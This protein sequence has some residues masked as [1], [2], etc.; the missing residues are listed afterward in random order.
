MALSCFS[1]SNSDCE[2]NSS[3]E[4]RREAWLVGGYINFLDAECLVC[5]GGWF[6]T[7]FANSSLD[8]EGLRDN[9][10]WCRVFYAFPAWLGWRLGLV[11]DCVLLTT[12]YGVVML[13]MGL[14]GPGLLP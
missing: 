12:D 10:L 14:E 5:E 3:V 13:T 8:L 7:R 2:Y 9:W 11:N 4:L 1:F 6:G